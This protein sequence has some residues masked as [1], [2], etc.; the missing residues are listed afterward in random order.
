MECY[1]TD[2]R[3]GVKC[4]LFFILLLL[5]NLG[6]GVGAT[7]KSEMDRARALIN[8]KKYEEAAE[9]LE[10]L[11]S[12]YPSDSQ[13]AYFLAQAHLG[14]GG[15]EMLEFVSQVTAP[16]EVEIELAGKKIIECD[17]GSI[18]RYQGQDIRCM[19]VRVSEHLFNAD[20]SHIL[21]A[22]F[23]L[24]RHF[25]TANGTR[26]DINFVSAL[27]ETG[28]ALSR[29]KLLLELGAPAHSS[30]TIA[31]RLSYVIHQ[32]KN[33][34]REFFWGLIRARFSYQKIRKLIATVD[35]RPILKIGKESLVFSEYLNEQEIFSFFPQAI[36]QYGP[37]IDRELNRQ[38]SELIQH[39]PVGLLRILKNVGFITF[40]KNVVVT[41]FQYG[42]AVD[43]FLQLATTTAEK[44]VQAPLEEMHF[45]ETVWQNPPP[46]LFKF[47]MALVQAWEHELGDP[48]VKYYEDTSK[49][50][51]DLGVLVSTWT[52]WW[53]N[54][55]TSQ[56][57]Q[58]MLEVL[59]NLGQQYPIISTPPAKMGGGDFGH[60]A[61]EVLKIFE[62]EMR[63][64]LSGGYGEVDPF[65]QHKIDQANELLKKSSSWVERNL[66]AGN[67]K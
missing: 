61:E 17:E 41:A 57:K 65:P 28:S 13:V 64:I 6:C 55:P 59:K 24:R 62:K 42:S 56:Q 2:Q 27:V 10:N 44:P 25:P 8:D 33:M 11:Y 47:K 21:R 29:F 43:S 32:I 15:F 22:K 7:K 46:I 3:R 48:I 60:W 51:T 63:Y 53:E 1:G 50:W 34:L 36:R 18:Q 40:E 66:W 49:E 19:L 58:Q 37:S 39:L 12:K 31:P 30:M 9:H 52:S 20:N 35:G 14:A 38:T 45:F 16:Q 23:L 67:E 5:L 54:A 26:S 4:C